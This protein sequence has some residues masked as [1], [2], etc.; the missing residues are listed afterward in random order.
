MLS[1]LQVRLWDRR[2]SGCIGHVS[3]PNIGTDPS[4]MPFAHS[5]VITAIDYVNTGEVLIT[6]CESLG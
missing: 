5:S 6:G 3:R 2:Q 1:L 4:G